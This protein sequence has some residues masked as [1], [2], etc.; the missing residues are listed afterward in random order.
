MGIS[1]IFFKRLFDAGR[2]SVIWR[3]THVAPGIHGHLAVP[4]SQWLRAVER[5]G[6]FSVPH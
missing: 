2:L 4:C 3:Q 5:S 1:T 6:F